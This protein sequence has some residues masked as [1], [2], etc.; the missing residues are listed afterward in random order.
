MEEVPA[1]IEPALFEDSIPSILA[2]HVVEIQRA[3]PQ[4]AYA[5]IWRSH[6]LV[7]R[8]LYEE[9]SAEFRFVER[10]DSRKF[11]MVPGVFRSQ[12]VDEF[13]LGGIRLTLRW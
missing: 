2:D 7:H 6:F 3:A 4:A 1:R 12:A 13:P 5:A 11:E 8:R 10:A 9:R